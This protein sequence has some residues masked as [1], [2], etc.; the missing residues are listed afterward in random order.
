M[1]ERRK[2]TS[3][4]LTM[5]EAVVYLKIPKNTLYKLVSQDRIPVSKITGSNRFDQ[6]LLDAWIKKNTRMPIINNT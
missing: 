2:I 4:F 3:R 6:A 5:D 1:N